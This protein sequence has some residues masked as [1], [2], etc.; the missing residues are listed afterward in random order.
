MSS[1]LEEGGDIKLNNRAEGKGS[2]GRVGDLQGD[3]RSHWK[4][5]CRL[6]RQN[7]DNA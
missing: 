6:H 1:P 7:T 5:T 3:M 2:E 4:G